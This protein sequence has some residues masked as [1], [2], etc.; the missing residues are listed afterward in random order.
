M[1]AIVSYTATVD[2]ELFNIISS[3]TGI[4]HEEINGDAQYKSTIN[5]DGEK[6]YKYL[7]QMLVL[8]GKLKRIASELEGVTRS[9][10]FTTLL[11]EFL[12][13]VNMSLCIK[14]GDKVFLD[15]SANLAEACKQPIR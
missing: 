8:F 14:G 3:L 13:A 2:Q 7:P 9:E 5:F 12:K 10:E 4:S 6:L 11:Q 15:Q 1:K